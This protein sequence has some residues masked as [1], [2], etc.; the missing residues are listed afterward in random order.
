MKSNRGSSMVFALL[1]MLGVL[2]LGVAGLQAAASGLTLSNN[3]KTGVQAIQAAES[4][5]V[6]AIGIMNNPGVLS[7]PESVVTPWSTLIGYSALTMPGNQ[8]G[9]SY[10]VAPTAS[11][12][13]AT[14]NTSMWITSIGQGPGE[15]TRTISAHLS[16]TGPFTCG[17]IDLPSSGINADFRG[18]AFTVDGNDY[19]MGSETPDPTLDTT[20][21][22]S[23]RA[24]TDADTIVTALNDNQEARVT[25]TAVPNQVPSVAPCIGPTT[26]YVRDTLVQNILGQPS[27][28]VVTDPEGNGNRDNI[29]GNLQIGSVAA[30]QITHFAGDTTIKGTGNVTGAGILIVDGGLTIT[31]SLSFTGLIIVRGATQITTVTGN[32]SVYGA[33]WTTDLSLTVGGSAAVR[34]SS[35]ALNLAATIPQTDGQYLPQHVKVLAWSQT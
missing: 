16:L 6:H 17:A 24:Q 33:I 11:P 10:T 35:A 21:G 34:Y 5:I 2:A 20:L 25:G 26:N 8:P 28:P 31:G 29:N 32:A 4:G 1:I 30:P 23:T 3:Y 27:P 13:S 15:A 9:I 19:P 12:P 22:I 14:T 7:F 18:Q